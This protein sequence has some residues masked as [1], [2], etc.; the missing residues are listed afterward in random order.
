M[1]QFLAI[2][3]GLFLASLIYFMSFLTGRGI[4]GSRSVSFLILTAKYLIYWVALSFGFKHLPQI[5][6]MIGF[7]G[8]I[9]LSLPVLYFYNKHTQG[10]DD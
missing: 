10:S 6:I 3:Y 2:F 8:G 1:I 9:F 7:T 4:M 5:E